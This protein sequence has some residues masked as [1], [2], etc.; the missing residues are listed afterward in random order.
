MNVFLRVDINIIAMVLLGVVSMIA[1]KRLDLKDQLNRVFLITSLII[2]L[3][4]FFETLTC[5]LNKRP[6][7][8]AAPVSTA[9]HFFLFAAGPILTYF[10]YMMICHWILPE[11]H[12]TKRHL[13]IMLIPATVNFILSLLTP[14]YGY[15]YYIDSSNIYHRGPLFLVSAAAVYFYLGYAFVLI[16]INKKKIVKEE[17]MP[18][19]IFGVLPIIGGVL[20]SLFY[21]ILLMWSCAGFSMLIVYIFLQQRMIHIDDLTGAWTRAT[22]EYCISR[23]TKQKNTNT[24]GLI[25]LDIDGL[26]RINDEHGHHE[27]DYALKMTVQLIKSVLQKNDII[28]RT[29]GDEFLIILDCTS[30][31]KIEQTIRKIRETLKQHN[32]SFNKGYLLDCSIGAELYHSGFHNINQ[33]MQHVDKLMYENKKIK[34]CS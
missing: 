6:E 16:C 7:I 3:E 13:L 15:L 31:D 25:I 23:R 8:W 14:L 4:L 11:E 30:K 20:Q 29:G 18:L 26:K 33:F 5:I 22:F 28:A 24:F 12:M 27:G 10:W 1:Y 21:G 17:Y 9:L 19:I 32:E 2:I 34:R